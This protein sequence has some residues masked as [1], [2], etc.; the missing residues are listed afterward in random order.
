MSPHLHCIKCFF[1]LSLGFTF[2]YTYLCCLVYT[3]ILIRIDM[4]TLPYEST[5]SCHLTDDFLP[6]NI[7]E[8]VTKYVSNPH[9]ACWA[10]FYDENDQIL[11]CLQNEEVSNAL[12][13]FGCKEEML[14]DLK[15]NINTRRSNDV[16]I[17]H[18]YVPIVQ[19]F[20]VLVSGHVFVLSKVASNLW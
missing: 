18:Q 15:N 16:H 12:K 19:D 3:Y 4:R 8:Y 10:N 11:V 13:K 7:S 9:K 1:A 2:A 17:H 5:L 14:D 6:L 20:K